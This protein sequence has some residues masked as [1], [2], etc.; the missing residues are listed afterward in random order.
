MNKIFNYIHDIE[1][2]EMDFLNQIL[3]QMTDEDFHQFMTVYAMRRKKANEILLLSLIGFLGIAGIHRFYLNQV[4]LGLLFLLT[5]GFCWI[6]TIVDII[7]HRKLTSDAN[8]LIAQE[9][10]NMMSRFNP[11]KS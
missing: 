1:E 5:I 4:G 2:R 10:L 9:T 8:I 7:N 6:G 3:P 11:H